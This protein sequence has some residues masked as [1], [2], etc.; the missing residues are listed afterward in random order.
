[1][2]SPLTDAEWDAHVTAA[3][4]R[5]LE[6]RQAGR[7]TFLEHANH[8][9]W[10]PE[11]ADV[12]EAIVTE[13]YQAAAQVPRDSRAVIAGGPW[14]PDASALALDHLREDPG[15][16]PYLVIEPD[17]VE[18][19]MA[20]RGLIPRIEGLTPLEAAHLVQREVTRIM[21]LLLF[22]A[23]QE[24]R[25]VLIADD[26][27]D[28]VLTGDRIARLRRA[29]YQEVA[30]F[31]L[32]I[33]LGDAGRRAQRGHRV[34]HERW[35]RAD[36]EGY[37][38]RL[39]PAE[40]FTEEWLVPHSRREV[41]DALRSRVDSWRRSA[42]AGP[43]RPLSLDDV[44]RPAQHRRLPVLPPM[45]GAEIVLSGEQWAALAA[46]GRDVTQASRRGSFFRA[47]LQTAG[48]QLEDWF[49]ARG[50]AV[51][52]VTHGMLRLAMLETLTL[53][54]STPGSRYER[55]LPTRHGGRISCGINYAKRKGTL[56]CWRISHRTW[57]LIRSA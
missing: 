48:P 15:G 21:D 45:P 37:G 57:P 24:R 14:L 23:T 2:P 6:A 32:D 28:R 43:A 4:E 8:G 50:G 7:A 1:V 41:F 5:L 52:E 11:R 54:L 26:M 29:G 56:R 53:D 34:G 40:T 30:A 25:N 51:L 3:E 35:R 38:G 13:M 42:Q 19:A 46:F 39:I 16:A 10:T 36:T 12:H 9:V 55:F 22:R 44:G 20:R 27:S 49:A 33:S 47:L 18:L 17:G 31:F